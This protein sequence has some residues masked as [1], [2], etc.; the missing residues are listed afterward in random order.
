M[1]PKIIHY[2]WL[3][4]NPLPEMVV[5]CMESW[6]K[7]CPDY[8]IKQWDESN[9]NVDFCK[10][11]RDAY[12][13]KKYAF[14]SDALRFKVLKENGGIYL[15]VD[16]ELLRPLDD[17]LDKKCFMGYEMYGKILS[18]N[19]GLILASEKNGKVVSGIY[20]RYLKDSFLDEFGKPKYE[21][22]CDKTV[23]YLK[24]NYQISI[25]GKT[26]HFNDFSIYS[27]E[28]F[29]PINGET[30]KLEC[31]TENTYS[32]H[33]YLASWVPKPNC[34]KR[35]EIAFKKFVKLIIG[36]KNT[37]RIKKKRKERRERKLNKEK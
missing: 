27:T 9:L 5:K 3:G 11:C 21:T 26:A 33:L 12:D 32:K 34:F 10:Y 16:V 7:F 36:K 15:D 2:I 22:V 8:E 35:M 25:D 1:I 37:E 6:K 28:Y 14:A 29:C 30:K 17:L 23:K 13:A 4:G 20:E 31:L 19:P 24:E 18:I